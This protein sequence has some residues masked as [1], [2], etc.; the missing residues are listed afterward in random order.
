MSIVDDK[1]IKNVVW[2]IFS[3]YRGSLD[4]IQFLDYILSLLFLKYVSD[5]MCDIHE[6]RV[7]DHDFKLKHLLSN[8]PENMSFNSIYSDINDRGIGERI[9]AALCY[10]D[11]AIFQKLYKC[12]R[13]VFSDIDFTSDKLGPRKER[14][15]FLSELMHVLNSRVFQFNSNNNGHDRIKSICGVLFEKVASD[16]GLRG[17]GFYTPYG[18]SVLLSKLITP[19]SGDSIYDPACGTGSLLLRA[20]QEISYANQSQHYK[21]YGQE[22]LKSSW[23]V[24]YINMFL[25]GV[26]SCSIKWGDVLLDPQFHDA[27]GEL[28]KFDVVLSNP[29]FSL[30][31]WGYDEALRDKFGRFALGIPPQSKADYAFILHM[32]ASMKDKTGRMALVAPHGVLF[33]GASEALIRENL[34]KENLLDAVIGLPERLFL[35]TNIPTVILIFK[36]NRNDSNVLF[37]DST[38]FFLKSK[39]RNY[40]TVENIE[41][42]SGIYHKR[43]DVENISR[44]VSFSEIKGNDYNLNITRYVKR[45]E[46]TQDIDLYSLI[47][48]QEKL[49]EELRSLEKE[50]KL[51][52]HF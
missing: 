15:A 2:D 26:Y 21:L 7:I 44:V 29:P 33:R 40:L 39:G 17:G 8:A 24:A 37:I 3:V 11:E 34:I 50:M 25:H 9:N 22:I 28:E 48:E 41:Q 19:V 20:M 35:S 36:K 32:I 46:K 6:D 38:M 43:H 49:Q 27:K 30:S 12:D 31:N 13:D 4:A 14:E 23:N 45:K 42:I 51:Y 10:Y 47:Y 18:V 5:L 52:I 1:E 16:A